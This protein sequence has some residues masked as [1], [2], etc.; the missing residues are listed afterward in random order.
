MD[1]IIRVC[2]KYRYV[3]LIFL[4]G[5]FLM[6][7]PVGEKPEEERLEISKALTEES[8]ETRLAAILSQMEGVGRTQVLL[9]IAAGEQT[10]YVQDENQSTGTDSGTYRSETILVT[11]TDR[12]EGGL[13]RQVLPPTYQGAIVVCQGGGSAAVRLAVVEAVSKAT[14]L[15]ADKITVLKMK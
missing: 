5:V 10:L 8:L 14:G 9:T 6:L 4:V 15:S 2:S 1:R 11:G 7:L 3:L 12:E 13:V